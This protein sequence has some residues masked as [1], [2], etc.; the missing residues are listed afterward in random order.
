MKRMKLVGMLT[1]VVLSVIV[2]L[3]NTQPVETRFLF[4]K[5]T[6]PNAILLGLT[7]LIGIAIGILVALTRSSK[8]HT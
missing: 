7:L 4:I 2:I 5:I 6:M 1:A 8:S 3:Q